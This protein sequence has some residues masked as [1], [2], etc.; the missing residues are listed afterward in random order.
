MIS[1]YEKKAYMTQYSNREWVSLIE[2]ISVDGRILSPYI[3]FKAVVYQQ[4]WFNAYPKAHIAIS[5]NGWTNNK[6]GLL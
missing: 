5:P 2:Y 1:K 6:I 3:I 4:A